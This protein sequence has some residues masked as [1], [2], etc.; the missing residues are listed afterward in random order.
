MI[1]ANLPALALAGLGRGGAFGA[2]FARFVGEKA[3]QVDYSES[4]PGRGMLTYQILTN[5]STGV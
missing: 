3:A 1:L 5:E 4:L 2:L